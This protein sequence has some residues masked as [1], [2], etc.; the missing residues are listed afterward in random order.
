MLAQVLVAKYSDHLPLYRQAQI[1]ARHGIDLDRS[2]PGL[3][4]GRLWRIGSEAPAGGCGRWRNCWSARSSRHPR[5]SPTTPYAIAARIRGRP[6]DEQR[7]FRQAETKPLVEGLKTWLEAELARISAKSAL[8]G[9][10]RYALRHWQGLV[11]FLQDGSIETDTNTVEHS[12]RPLKLGCKNHLFAG[13]DGGAECWVT[14]ASLIQTAKLN[15]VEPF[16]YLRDVLERIV[17]G[18]TK[19][20]DLASLLPSAW[21]ASQA[22]TAVNT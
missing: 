14:L 19:A 11:L 6:P 8:A 3:R 9:A 21:K 10:I 13:S 12:I 7:R 20:N 18:K 4:G 1:F 17:S 2:T 16:A 22:Q 5:S 15:D